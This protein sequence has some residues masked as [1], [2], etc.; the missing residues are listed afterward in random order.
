M[1]AAILASSGGG[2]NFYEAVDMAVSTLDVLENADE[3]CC[4]RLL[5]RFLWNWA[6]LLGQQPGLERCSS[7]ACE[8][9]DDGLLWFI[10]GEGLLCTGCFHRS[11]GSARPAVFSGTEPAVGRGA[12]R[13]L[14]AAEKQ[15]PSALIRMS[16][17][18]VS[19]AEAKALTES[20]INDC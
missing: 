9:G 6:G 3:D 1:A 14:A 4:T 10:R 16:L 8:A 5:V 11:C 15:S 17:D 18:A 13:W 19:L 2:G 20:I 7:C 12:R